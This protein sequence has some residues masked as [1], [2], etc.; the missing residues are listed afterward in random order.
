MVKQILSRCS[1]AERREER[2]GIGKIGDNLVLPSTLL[3]YGASFDAFR[4]FIQRLA[5]R[6]TSTIPEY[7]DFALVEYLE[8]LWQEG[9]G[10]A[11]GNYTLAGLLHFVPSLRGEL[12]CAR[13][14]LKGWHRLELPARAAPLT[15]DMILAM[16]GLFVLWDLPFVAY[17]LLIGFDLFLRTNELAGLRL[18][19]FT[20]SSDRSSCVLS[21]LDGTKTSS[22]K[23]ASS[24]A[25]VV[26]DPLVLHLI[27]RVLK[28]SRGLLAGD[29]AAGVSPSQF[30]RY[31]GKAV[32]FLKLGDFNVRPY[33]I[34]RGGATQHFRLHGNMA[35]TVVRG[36]W[37][38]AKTARI[39]I[40]DGLSCLAQLRLS[41]SQVVDFE[42]LKKL[43]LRHCDNCGQLGNSS[44][45]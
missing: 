44:L 18:G 3:R 28:P 10:V 32:S 31:F 8:H 38:S 5:I 41:K 30:V 35:D 16:G 39:Y 1:K 21:L 9:E 37:A 23:T 6:R 13:R 15:M 36:R 2:A 25:L 19:M 42:I 22:R 11:V 14:I 45:R 34:R 17:S 24:E 33:S 27:Q 4:S 29:F 7:I 20:M 26:R 12:H 40:E 43:F